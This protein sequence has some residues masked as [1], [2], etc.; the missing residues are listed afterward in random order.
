MQTAYVGK[1]VYNYDSCI[2]GI[3]E[4]GKGFYSPSD[5]CLGSNRSLYV[6]CKNREAVAGQGITKLT[7]D[8]E[9][10]WE[11]RGTPFFQGQGPLP[12]AVT[13]DSDEK[14]YVCDE[15]TNEI[16]VYD[17]D[18]SPSGT[19]E[20]EGQQ[21][22]DPA[23]QVLPIATTTGLPLELYL[24][25]VGARDTSRDGA[26]NGPMGLAFDAQDRL[27][28]SDSHNHRSAEFQLD[29]R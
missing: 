20:H 5:F 7:L 15:Y 17:K 2:G 6:L 19:W 21:K 16:F 13:V 29:E 10:L 25:K 28:V 27:Y 22:A 18:G 24:K 4:A 12:S 11:C 26:F 3:A 8:S 1:R 9:L 14:V 23:S